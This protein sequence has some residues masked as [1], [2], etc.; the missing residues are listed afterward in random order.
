MKVPVITGAQ[1]SNSHIDW[2]LLVNQRNILE[3]LS[4]RSEAWLNYRSH[5]LAFTTSK[6]DLLEKL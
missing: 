2:R 1:V 4:V 3:N 5:A 6:Q